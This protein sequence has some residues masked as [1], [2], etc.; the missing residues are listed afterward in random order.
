MPL[1]T[2]L[3]IDQGHVIRD[4]APNPRFRVAR[5]LAFRGQAVSI[6][7]AGNCERRRPLPGASV[8]RL[9]RRI[10]LLTGTV[11]PHRFRH[12]FATWAIWA[13]ARE[14]DVQSL[15]GHLSLAMVERYA[16]TYSSEQAVQGHRL[17]SPVGQLR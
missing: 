10:S 12:T 16:R 14:I 6:T 15:L 4:P 9:C 2:F 3:A 11:H 13:N 5:M 17:F 1:S 7:D 8:V